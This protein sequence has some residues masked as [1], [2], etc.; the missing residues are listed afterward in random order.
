MSMRQ[1]HVMNVLSKYCKKYFLY[2]H[3]PERTDDTKVIFRNATRR[4][5]EDP[6]GE[7]D[8]KRRRSYKSYLPTGGWP[9]LELD[10]LVLDVLK[11]QLD[12]EG[13]S[14]IYKAIQRRRPPVPPK[15]E[16]SP[17]ESVL[18]DTSDLHE[19][20]AAG[21]S[22]IKSYLKETEDRIHYVSAGND[23][24]DHFERC[25]EN[26]M[27]ELEPASGD[28]SCVSADG[29]ALRSSKERLRA[30]EIK[31][32]QAL[33][34]LLK[35]LLLVR[36]RHLE[37]TE[38]INLKILGTH[39]D[40]YQGRGI[41]LRSALRH[42]SM[43]PDFKAQ[44]VTGAPPG[45]IP[46]FLQH[47]EGRQHT[48]FRSR[49]T[50]AGSH[51]YSSVRY[52]LTSES[53]TSLQPTSR[54]SSLSS[55]LDK[56]IQTEAKHGPKQSIVKSPSVSSFQQSKKIAKEDPKE[57]PLS[58]IFRQ[59]WPTL[60]QGV[61]AVQQG[62][63]FGRPYTAPARPKAENRTR[64]KS[65]TDIKNTRTEW[66]T[67]RNYMEKRVDEEL[68]R[69]D[70]EK[71]EF[72]DICFDSLRNVPTGRAFELQQ[73][74]IEQDFLRCRYLRQKRVLYDY[75]VKSSWYKELQDDMYERFGKHNEAMN[76]LMDQIRPYFKL[77][78]TEP[79]LGQAK[80]AL[81]VMSMP[82]TEIC[83][84]HV[85][86]ALDF[87]VQKVMEAPPE[88]LKVWLG[89]RNLPLVLLSELVE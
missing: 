47:H 38:P 69:A 63:N 12:P 61:A 35:T 40:T 45:W 22:K 6:Y 55:V 62:T 13:K 51:K 70:K 77:S 41:P 82:A 89:T 64:M 56:D 72:F 73:R 28:E 76:A 80:M 7:T 74:M 17:D 87:I 88:T 16:A 31:F 23:F 49:T 71:M 20:I 68:E 52:S 8:K 67:A 21:F 54:I 81:I 48:G 78:P 2:K 14:V 15:V 10:D 43:A 37:S 27:A 86:R 33:R 29:A 66:A 75:E 44:I 9:I 4:L 34:D 53:A 83:Y 32:L 59:R 5:D 85:Q 30:D 26:H 19:S 39:R 79:K 65:V 42:R 57:E 60:W 50:D 3:T 58:R 18:R 11:E 36:T 46:P 1:Q 84:I 24:R 25:L